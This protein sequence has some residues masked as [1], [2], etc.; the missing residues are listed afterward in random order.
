MKN[1]VDIIKFLHTTENIFGNI[2]FYICG[3]ITNATDQEENIRN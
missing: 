2:V 1:H 3:E